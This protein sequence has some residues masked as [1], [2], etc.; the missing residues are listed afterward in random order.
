MR[1]AG[2]QFLSSS[3]QQPL[4]LCDRTCTEQIALLFVDIPCLVA[5]TPFN[6]YKLISKQ[7]LITL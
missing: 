6:G 3:P 7:N 5:M 2:M 4:M 1:I